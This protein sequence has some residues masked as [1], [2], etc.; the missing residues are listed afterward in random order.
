MIVLAPGR[1]SITICWPHSSDNLAAT[2]RATISPA[3]AAASGTT[4]RIGRFGKPCANADAADA[5]S[6]ASARCLIAR[7]T[8]GEKWRHFF[9]PFEL[10]DVGDDTR[11]TGVADD[12][13]A[14]R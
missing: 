11:G 9:K 1:L 7:L 6:S 12:G 14:V 8:P 2:V 13:I 4:K 5:K 3:P 10:P